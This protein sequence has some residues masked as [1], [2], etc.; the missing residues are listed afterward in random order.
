MLRIENEAYDIPQNFPIRASTVALDY[1]WVTIAGQ[2]EYLLPARSVVV[3]TAAE[4][5]RTVQFRNDIRFR[6]YQKFGTELKIIE[7]DDFVDEPVQE[8][9]NQEAPP[10]ATPPK[11]PEKKP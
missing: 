6:D 9:P 2:G 8:T 10:N 1:D 7:D 5:G 4:G 11:P 3:L